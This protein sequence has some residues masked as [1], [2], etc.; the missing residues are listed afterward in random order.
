MTVSFVATRYAA[1]ERVAAL[2]SRR[3]IR[4]SVSMTSPNT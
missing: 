2:A 1:A 3:E 4:K